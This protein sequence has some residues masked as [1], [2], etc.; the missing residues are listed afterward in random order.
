[1][2]IY[3]FILALVFMLIQ[4]GMLF[5]QPS[6]AQWT[7][8]LKKHVSESGAVNYKGLAQDRSEID[9]YLNVLRKARPDESKWSRDEQ[10]AYWINAYNAFTIEL[11]LDHYPIKSI[12]DIAGGLI[13][14]NTPWD[15]SFIHLQ[16]KTFSLNDIEH[17]IIRKNFEDPRI[18]F[19]LVCAAKSCPQLRRESYE[20]STLSAQLDDQGKLFLN[21]PSK[22]NVSPSKALL[23]PLFN[24]YGMDFK[25][26]GTLAEWVSRYSSVPLAKQRIE[27]GEYDWSLND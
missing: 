6:H 13:G 10:L 15:I 14:I 19:A 3:A 16:G 20:A 8:L 26:S 18:H 9:A 25:K 1:M 21:D 11:V 2:R 4:Q 7:S 23:S 22:N 12:K 17:H 27:Y 5:S 24:W